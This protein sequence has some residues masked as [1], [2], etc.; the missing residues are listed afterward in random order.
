ME[1]TGGGLDS[2]SVLESLRLTPF[3]NE[4]IERRGPAVSR[5]TILN[6]LNSS[7]WEKKR[8]FP[9][10][11]LTDRQKQR[12]LDWCHAHS[13]FDWE[14]DFFKDK[15]QFRCIQ[16]S[17]RNGQKN[18][19]HPKHSP[20]FHVWGGVSSWGTMPLC[21]FNKKSDKGSVCSHSARLP[22]TNCT[23]FV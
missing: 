11:S 18:N 9:A 16:L 19:K 8:A 14:K 13:I 6:E 23:G 4:M 2:W 22:P 20:K 1:R 5:Q 21:M 7:D 10:L 15:V 12:R 3:R 17:L